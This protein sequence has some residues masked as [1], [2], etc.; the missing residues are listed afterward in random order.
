MNELTG[1]GKYMDEFERILYNNVL[2]SISLSGDHYSYENPLDAENNPRWNWHSCP[3][4][5]PMFLKMVAALPG[6]IY[7]YT[8]SEVYVN[9]FIG[10]ETKIK[11]NNMQEVLLKQTTNYPWDGKID[12]SIEPNLERVF[13]LKIRIPGWALGKE[14][15]Y[16]LYHSSLKSSIK[17]CVN[18]KSVAINPNNGYMAIKRKWKKSD[19]VELTLPMEPRLI[20]ANN[21][22][23][24]LKNMI[25]IASGPI[26]YCLEKYDNPELKDIRL[27]VNSLF[28][29]TYKPEVLNGVNIINGN[30]LV[31]SSKNGYDFKQVVVS[32]IPF[33]AVGNR[34]PGNAYEVW[35]PQ[36]K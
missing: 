12:I 1:N 2:S 4:C 35:I 25:A 11:F 8:S 5:P 18:G 27:E 17:L 33:Y 9:L 32:A 14:N 24:E 28:K 26:V 34:E 13:S 29:I 16:M 22:V 19:M 20:Y 10:N 36:N 7:S 23:K 3:C 30:A 31:D 21:S 6:F 15:P